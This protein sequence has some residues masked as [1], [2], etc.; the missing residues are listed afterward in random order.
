MWTWRPHQKFSQLGPTAPKASPGYSH[1]LKSSYCWLTDLACWGQ[2]SYP[3]L[4]VFLEVVRVWNRSMEVDGCWICCTREKLL[5][6]CIVL[7]SY[8]QSKLVLPTRE[9]K[10][11]SSSTPPGESRVPLIPLAAWS[12]ASTIPSILTPQVGTCYCVYLF[13]M[14]YL[15]EKLL[16]KWLQ[17]K[18]HSVHF[19]FYHIG[20]FL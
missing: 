7:S 2:L 12:L 3:F 18:F 10:V 17:V 13:L 5:L 15:F 11:S 9:V 20:N 8:E 14:L 4:Y 19:Q 16:R 6:S 1:P